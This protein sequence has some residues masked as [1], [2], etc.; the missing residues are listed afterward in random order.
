VEIL[1]IIVLA[2]EGDTRGRCKE[3][4]EV[5][6]LQHL[7]NGGRWCLESFQLFS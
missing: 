4:Q 2:R 3:D 6:N 7:A 5:P 1:E